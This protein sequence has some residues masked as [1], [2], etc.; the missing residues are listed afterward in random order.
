MDKF[1]VRN[2]ELF[3]P[4]SPDG[5]S[6]ADILDFRPGV[7]WSMRG[8]GTI[9]YF[10]ILSPLA[11]G[12]SN[13]FKSL[14]LSGNPNILSNL[15]GFSLRN[16]LHNIWVFFVTAVKIFLWT[17]CL[18]IP[19]V[20]KSFSYSMV[21]YIMV[22][23]PEYSVQMCTQESSRI[24]Q[25]HK[26]ELFMLYLSFIGWILLSIIS[27]GIGFFWLIPYMNTAQAAFYDDIRDREIV[28]PTLN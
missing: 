24:M 2:L 18:I 6:L 1:T 26:I 14:Y 9:L 13:A 20:I 8:S 12:I 15:A 4:S 21:P 23:H 5:K 16:Y 28:I 22:E 3:Q 7:I 17:L 27:C 10:F 25:G 19:G 11:I